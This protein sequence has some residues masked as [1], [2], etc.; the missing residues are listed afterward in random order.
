MQS[1]I[2][3]GEFTIER[4]YN[5][6][7][8]KVYD[9]FVDK[10]L[11]AKWFGASDEYELDFRVG[12][13]EVNIA[14]PHEGTVF[15]YEALYYDIVPNQRIIYSYEMYMGDRRLSVSLA[16]IE[17]AEAD[18]K[19]TLTLREDGAFLDD[20]DTSEVRERG[21][22]GLLDRLEAILR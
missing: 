14:I 9:A 10:T 12:G 8:G 7:L 13:K 19:T 6:P 1:T 16:T 20:N 3:H 15:R 5:A 17:F 4:S 11:K 2:Q 21:T 22:R 18:G